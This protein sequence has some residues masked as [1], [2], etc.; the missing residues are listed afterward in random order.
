MDILISIL[1]LFSPGIIYLWY[2]H[3]KK[4]ADLLTG[5]RTLEDIRAEE[6]AHPFF[7]HPDNPVTSIMNPDNPVSPWFM[8]D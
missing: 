8:E 3:A 6:E 5:K 1:I 7:M 4:K 2:N